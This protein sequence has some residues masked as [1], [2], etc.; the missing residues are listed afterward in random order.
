MQLSSFDV[1]W[2]EFGFQWA[3]RRGVVNL[4]DESMDVKKNG[5]LFLL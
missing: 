1:I 5:A 4:V 3:D 2:N